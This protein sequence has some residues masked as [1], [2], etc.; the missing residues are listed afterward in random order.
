MLSLIALAAAL[1]AA[2]PDA[3]DA[4]HAEGRLLP[5]RERR[6]G[7]LR[8]RRPGR[9]RA[10]G[11]AAGRGRSTTPTSASTSSRSS[12][13]PPTAPLYS[14]GFASIYGEWETTDEAKR[15]CPHVPRVAALPGAA[16][17]GPGRPQEARP[18]QRSSARSGP[19]RSTPSTRSSTARPARRPKPSGPCSRTAPP[20][21]KVDL[22]LMGDGY[23]RPRWRSGTRTRSGSSSLLFAASPFRSGGPTSTCGPSTRPPDESGVRRPSDG[24]LRARPCAPPTTSS[25]PS[26]TSS[27]STTAR[28][29]RWPLPRRTSSWRSWSTRR[30]Y[31][32]GGIFNL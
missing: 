4:A 9:S 6:R 30:K 13:A 23:T 31:G 3:A 2:P 8:A 17:P 12:T 24:V 29:A 25:T 22:L 21:D 26:A 10:R 15:A 11:R 18:R 28:C 14:R 1:A 20:R 16:G 5:H 27:S 7:A 19:S 32:G